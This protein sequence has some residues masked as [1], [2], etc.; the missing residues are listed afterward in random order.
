MTMASC[1]SDNA[2]I[3][4]DGEYCSQ[5]YLCEL[6]SPA[7]IPDGSL[8]VAGNLQSITARALDQRDS[9]GKVPRNRTKKQPLS[10]NDMKWTLLPKRDDCLSIHQGFVMMLLKAAPAACVVSRY[11][12]WHS[13]ARKARESGLKMKALARRIA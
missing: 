3:R 13:K 10:L 1:M 2:I 5:E 7:F 11:V 9:H 12:R 8:P 6:T 4:Q